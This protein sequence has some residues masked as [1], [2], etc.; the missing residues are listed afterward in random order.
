MLRLRS[1]GAHTMVVRALESI[2][3]ASGLVACGTPASDASGPGNT[4]RA[5]A[6]PACT[7]DDDAD[8]DDQQEDP[9]AQS[10]DDTS[11]SASGSTDDA[12]DKPATGD[13][14]LFCAARAVIADACQGCHSAEP[15]GGAPMPLVT[16]DDFV[17][18]APIS[19][20]ELV[21]EAIAERIHDTK[22]PMPPQ[23]ALS[24]DKLAAID[25]WIEGGA[26][27]GDDPTCA[28]QGEDEDL[29]PVAEQVWP[30][31]GSEDCYKLTVP[32][33]TVEAGTEV[34]PQF[35]FDAP[36][37]DA[38]VQ[39][40]GFRPITDNKKILHH[41]ILYS[42]TGVGG[43]L[44]GWAPGQDASVHKPLPT[45]VG[46]AMPSGPGAMRLDMHYY[47]TQGTSEEHDESGVEVCITRKLREKPAGTYMGF[48][49]IPILPAGE[50]TDTVGNCDVT[51]SEPVYILSES[52][53]AHQ[54]AYWAKFE[55]KRGGET[56]VLHDKAF[57]FAEQTATPLD[58]P[59]EL[60]TGDQVTTTCRYDNET[61]NLVTF[62]EN[63]GNEMCFNF[64]TIY[65]LGALS[66]GFGL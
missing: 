12:P 62:G 21:Y 9:P 22:R 2:L 47:N 14:S 56:I 65:P 16:F 58:E 24:A 27:P 33:A 15:V 29:P 11:D 51:V 63:T 46:I 43:F 59:F 60:K 28:G 41:W 38:E 31:E 7:P 25:A 18:P 53:H 61:T 6:A 20:D 32:D 64:A 4:L 23:G 3:L 26:K 54:L 19:E 5:E 37:G 17:A 13:P 35:F 39:A 50:K 57:N 40:L 42:G 66:C 34:H 52:P 48:V 36:W 30:P 10:D 49:G 8:T 1:G 45:D 55:I 44:S